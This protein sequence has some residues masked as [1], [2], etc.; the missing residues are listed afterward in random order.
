MKINKVILDNIRS[1]N[2]TSVNINNGV[3]VLTGRTGSGKSSILMAIEY[4]LFGSSVIS[5]SA[6]LKRG[7]NKGNV[8]IEFEESG[9]TYEL[10]RGLKRKGDKP[11]VDPDALRIRKN[12]IDIPLVGRD[13]DLTQY[14]LKILGYPSESPAKS[15][16]EVTSYCKQDEIRQIIEMSSTNRQEYI[17][18][19]LQLSK[20]QDT[21]VNMRSILDFF[22][23]KKESLQIVIKEIYTFEKEILEA[24][25]KIVNRRAKKDD[26]NTNL[27]IVSEDLSKK[28]EEKKR[29]DDVV[30]KIKENY[31][32]FL[33]SKSNIQSLK[34]HVETKQKERDFFKSD[35]QKL[36]EE[37]INFKEVESLSEVEKK[38]GEINGK[39][40]LIAESKRKIQKEYSSV[41]DLKQG[42]CP[43]C[44][45]T[46]TED[47]ISHIND[48]YEKEIR[49]LDYD[50][51]DLNSKILPLSGMKEKSERKQQIL[52]SVKLLME[53]IDDRE[54]SIST[55]TEDL[56]KY[57]N[58]LIN[59]GSV[60]EEFNS[61]NKD[62]EVLNTDLI[63]ISSKKSSLEKEFKML[64]QELVEIQKD[65]DG[66]KKKL[67]NMKENQKEADKISI[68]LDLLERLRVDIRQIREV[69]R[70]KFL[71]NF[72]YAFQKKFEEIR[73]ENEYLVDI[74]ASYEPVAFSE[75]RS[76]PIDHLSGGEKT[77]VALA[78]RL[79]L[80]NIAA[81]MANVHP[82]EILI[83][84]EPTVGLD[85][86]D[87]K[88][89]PEVLRSIKTIPQ[90]IIVTHSEELKEAADYK[91]NVLKKDSISRISEV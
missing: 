60:D 49:K 10:T 28:M 58:E 56:R 26:V 24:E 91:Y 86:E 88:A 3:T 53:K 4:G 67:E 54:K 42:V 17:D 47:R 19:I 21:F 20:Y 22:K 36:D 71:E 79:A 43:K 44:K 77:S 31:N 82:S 63:S 40:S 8:T 41:R 61:I 74:K 39:L 80:A 15:L 51:E 34:T 83:L 55:D 57:E 73:T 81:Q 90:I 70:D 48:E 27:V 25:Q 66:R 13:S 32:K 33:H 75:K 52:D 18:Q 59:L 16:F 62:L 89:L 64:G 11:G 29:I 14:V 1:H 9:D 72:R 46:I 45:Q 37:G 7:I 85:G 38:I 84:D 69:I 65:F 35:L 5:P 78:Y 12:G 6:L 87:I 50:M 76:V 23:T 2:K 30:N 68:L